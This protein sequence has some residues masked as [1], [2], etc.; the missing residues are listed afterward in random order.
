MSAPWIAALP[1]YDF[2][3]LADAHERLWSALKRQL[4][5]AGLADVPAGLTRDRNPEELW[6]D[7]RLLLGQGCEYP[8]AKL[9]GERIRL[10]A[11]PRYT[12]PGCHGATYRSAVLVRKTDPAKTLADLRGRRC[13]IN[14]HYS[15]SGMNLL[16]ASIAP[17]AGGPRFFESVEVS[18]S[19]R[20]SVQSVAAGEAEVCAVDCVTKV[21]L[22]RLYPA[23]GIG[24]LRVLHWTAATPSLPMIA[25][26]AA[27]VETIAGIRAA[28]KGLM[29]DPALG[30][31][32]ARLYLEGFDLAPRGAFSEVLHLEREASRLGY[33]ELI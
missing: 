10:V 13:V 19:H 16:R 33:P 27:S 6:S 7:P 21:H 14:E 8:L 3:A 25:S 31:T 32:R 28:L 26:A 9:F 18:G 1:M 23:G 22:E 15:N 11:T 4:E 29:L 20:Q 17:I 30:A 5:R 2:P 12:V 24:A